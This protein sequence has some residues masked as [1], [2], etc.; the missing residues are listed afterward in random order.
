MSNETKKAELRLIWLIDVAPSQVWQRPGRGQHMRLHAT[1]QDV[2]EISQA[3]AESSILGFWHTLYGYLH[4]TGEASVLPL[5]ILLVA[6]VA[7]QTVTSQLKSLATD[8]VNDQSLRDVTVDLLSFAELQN[9]FSELEALKV[10]LLCSH[11]CSDSLASTSA[12][13]TAYAQPAVT[14]VCRAYATK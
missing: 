4:R 13:T 3:A 5:T 11:R 8:S 9:V 12:V 14:I 10:I 6:N 2:V 1:D 7:D